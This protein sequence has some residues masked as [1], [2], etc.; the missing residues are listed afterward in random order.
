[1]AVPSAIELTL[2]AEWAHHVSDSGA[3]GGH[4]VLEF[5]WFRDQI[6]EA[7]VIRL[8]IA[9]WEREYSQHTVAVFSGAQVASITQVSHDPEDIELPW[10]IVGFACQDVGDGCWA[11]NLNCHH[12]RCAWTSKWP[13]IERGAST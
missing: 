13:T 9:P 3:V 2:Y 6:A 4:C 7:D 10:G 11:F 8:R 1:M 5:A 12:L